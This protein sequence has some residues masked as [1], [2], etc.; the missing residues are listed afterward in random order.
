MC[1]SNHQ[2]DND[3]GMT[4]SCQVRVGVRIRPLTS[5]EV[6]HGGKCVIEAVPPQVGIG[7]RKFTY[8]SVFDSHVSQQDLYNRVAPSLLSSF[9]EG[10]NATVCSRRA[11]ACVC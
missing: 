8:D 4:N 9:L 3:D 5:K 10:Y 2:V 7:K 11:F 6:S 1:Q